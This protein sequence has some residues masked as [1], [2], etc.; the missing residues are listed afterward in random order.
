MLRYHSD[1][2]NIYSICSPRLLLTITFMQM[3]ATGVDD[4][5]DVSYMRVRTQS[6]K[7]QYSKSYNIPGGYQHET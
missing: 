6:T 1:E 2:M 3:A 4:A 7:L 5:D